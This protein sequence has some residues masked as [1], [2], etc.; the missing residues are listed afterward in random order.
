MVFVFW[1]GLKFQTSY[2]AYYDDIREKNIWIKIYS[3]VSLN[4]TLA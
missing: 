3:G 4:I 2:N 1:K